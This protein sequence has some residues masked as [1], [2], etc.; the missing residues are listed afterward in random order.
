M[1]KETFCFLDYEF[2]RDAEAGGGQVENVVGIF[3]EV[4]RITKD[5]RNGGTSDEYWQNAIKQFLRN[6]ISLLVLA[7][8]SV[9]LPN[10]KAAIDTTLRSNDVAENLKIFIRVRGILRRNKCHGTMG[11]RRTVQGCLCPV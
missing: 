3:L 9:T 10:I 5:K 7:E 8:E 1:S 2:S 11:I 6:T 4:V